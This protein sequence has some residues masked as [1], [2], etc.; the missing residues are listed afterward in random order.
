MILSDSEIKVENKNTFGS[1]I[2]FSSLLQQTIF[3]PITAAVCENE[4]T[5]LCQ[6]LLNNR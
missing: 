2:C 5:K 6:I 3:Y 4:P 1:C